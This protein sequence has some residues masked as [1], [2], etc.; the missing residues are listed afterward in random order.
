MGEASR[1]PIYYHGWVRE[2]EYEVAPIGAR[3]QSEQRSKDLTSPLCGT[4]S[5]VMFIYMFSDS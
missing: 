2:T 3:D 5:N 1:R 4:E